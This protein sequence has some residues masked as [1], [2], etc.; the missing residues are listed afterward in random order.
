MHLLTWSR[1]RGDSRQLASREVSL[2]SWQNPPTNTFASYPGIC[3][4][5]KAA[6]EADSVLVLQRAL[7]Q[8]CWYKC[9]DWIAA[10]LAEVQV[11]CQVSGKVAEG[12]PSVTRPATA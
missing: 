4:P 3:K 10:H 12:V 2:Y 5:P 6:T 9:A 11:R 1:L 7:L 8:P